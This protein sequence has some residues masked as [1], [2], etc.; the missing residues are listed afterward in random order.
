MTSIRV[1]QIGEKGLVI[2]NKEGEGK[3]I[4][5]DAVVI[6]T[7]ASPNNALLKNVESKVPEVYAIGDC[8]EPRNLMEAI[9]D[10][11]YAARAL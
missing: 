8:A 4:E 9:S 7:G 6:A 5:A 11:F 2:T 1:E 3:F 10:G